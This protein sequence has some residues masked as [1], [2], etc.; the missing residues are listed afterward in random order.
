[1]KIKLP[2]DCIISV[3]YD[4]ELIFCIGEKHDAKAT[5]EDAICD[6]TSFEQVE[7]IEPEDFDMD[8]AKTLSFR[9]SYEPEGELMEDGFI[10]MYVQTLY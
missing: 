9:A 1:M 8:I 2:K 10:E 3:Y 6:N 4:S 7:L 5:I